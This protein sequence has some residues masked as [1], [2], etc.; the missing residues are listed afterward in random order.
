[1][2]NCAQAPHRYNV[3]PRGR[4]V[5]LRFLLFAAIACL[6]ACA[7]RQSPQAAY[8]HAK[9][10]FVHGDLATSQHE[11]E[12]G[13]QRFRNSSPEWAWRFRVLEGQSLLWS[14]SYREVLTLFESP[15]ADSAPEDLHVSILA[16]QAVALARQHDL[17]RAEEKLKET[18]RLCAANSL[19]G[20]GEAFQARGLFALGQNQYAEARQHFLRSLAFARAKEDAFLETTSLLNLGGVLVKE[21]RYDEAVDSSD[22]AYKAALALKADD[23]A[24]AAQENLAWSY[25][26]LGDSARALDLMV[27]AEK[28]AEQLGDTFNEENGLTNIGYVYLDERR[29][30]LAEAAFSHALA[31]SRVENRKEH[32]LNAL[33]VLARLSLQMGDAV[34]ASEYA[35]EALKIARESGNHADEIYPTLVQGQ[36]AARR[37]DAGKAGQIFQA[38]EGDSVCPASLRWEAQHSLARLYEEQKQAV[39]ADRE[40]RTSL[41][42]FEAA[43]A[44]VRHEDFRLSFVTNGARIYDDYVHFLVAQGTPE[45]ALRWADY[46]RART[47]AEGLGLLSNEPTSANSRPNQLEPPRFDARSIARR[48][49]GTLLFYWLGEKQSYLW[50]ITS[51]RTELFTLPPGPEIEVA[52]RRYGKLLKGPQDAL[53]SSGDARSLYGM[54]IAPAQS[55]LAEEAKV[56]ILPDGVLNNLNF[57]TL[58]VAS[59]KP[60]YWIE[61]ADVVNASS[62]RVLAAS[63]ARRETGSRRLLLIGDSVA[64]SNDYPELP[65]AADQMAS[66]ASYFSASQQRVYQHEQATPAAY[67]QNHPEQ[68]SHI[69]FVAHGTASRLSPLDSAIVLSKEASN[70]DSFKLYARDI[71]HHRLHADLVTIS[72]CYGAGERQYSGEGLV[73]LAWAFQFA[74]ARNVIAAL[75]EVTDASTDQLMNRFYQELAKGAPPDAA[76]RT[77]K[78]ALLRGSAFH[79]PFYWAPFQLYTG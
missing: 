23:I 2:P 52:V 30:E 34:K 74:G 47:L 11:A 9:E 35:A 61:D 5:F 31:Q 60:H 45:Q 67:L 12:R 68:F 50:A 14:G 64:V 24:L 22:G 48:A 36:I 28:R 26:R 20:C 65:K 4:S 15:A 16:L 49:R 66:V 19:E 54:L 53:Q 46:S 40:Y 25:Y 56:F 70:P 13:Y 59:P 41:A 77:A 27:V 10:T 62:L 79:N 38:V 51:Q 39:A 1:M 73:G 17:G 63:L 32:M 37:G 7:P 33:R 55:L 8:E 78:L 3:Q 57:E 42:T 75:W 71:I 58:V 44:D 43:R 6:G 29:F 76:L 18:D 69:H 21:G 72:A